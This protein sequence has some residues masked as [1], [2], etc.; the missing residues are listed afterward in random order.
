[1]K[2]NLNITIDNEDKFSAEPLFRKALEEGF[3][4]IHIM[5]YNEIDQRR[6][7]RINITEEN[8]TIK[9]EQDDRILV[10]CVLEI[11]EKEADDKLTNILFSIIENTRIK[12]QAA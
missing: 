5:L 9:L 12:D 1:M 11:P 8:W 7:V 4:N 10:D 3:V 2:Q 6:D